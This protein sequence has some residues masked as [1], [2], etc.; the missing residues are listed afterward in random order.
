M[1]LDDGSDVFGRQQRLHCRGNKKSGHTVC[2]CSWF[3]SD[4]GTFVGTAHHL[5]FDGTQPREKQPCQPMVTRTV[6]TL[7]SLAVLQPPQKDS[8]DL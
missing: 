4:R 6:E 7:L 2:R 5:P 3:T 8:D 1:R